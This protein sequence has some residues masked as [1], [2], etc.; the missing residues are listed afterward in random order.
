MT[1]G[2]SPWDQ[3]VDKASSHKMLH[4]CAGLMTGKVPRCVVRGE[5]AASRMLVP[6]LKLK[7][8]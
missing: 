6:V 3:C 8:S 1:L 2:P 4:A 5:L 7:P